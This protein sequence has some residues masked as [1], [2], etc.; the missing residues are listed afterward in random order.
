VLNTARFII[1]KQSF[2]NDRALACVAFFLM[3]P[4]FPIHPSPRFTSVRLLPQAVRPQENLH[5]VLSRAQLTPPLRS[6]SFWLRF[7]PDGRYL[8]AQDFSGVSI[9]SVEPLKFLGYIEVENTYHAFFTPDSKAIRIVSSDLRVAT[10]KVENTDQLD[11][12]TLLKG[13]SCLSVS[14]SNS[15][16]RF[17]C[18]QHDFTLKVFDLET[19]EETYSETFSDN[20]AVALQLETDGLH[21]GQIAYIP[22]NPWAPLAHNFVEAIPIFFSPDGQ[23]LIIAAPRGGASRIDLR[24]KRKL[25]V[26]GS[27]KGHLHSTFVWLEGDRVLAFEH[28]A[29]D[30]S[31]IFSLEAG[32]V[33]SAVPFTTD[34][35]QAASNA[36]YLL[37][38]QAGTPGARVFDLIENRLLDVPDN[39]GLD[40]FGPVL[41][42]L[43][44]N[45]DLF[46]YHIGDKLPYRVTQVPLGSLTQIRTAELDSSLKFIG[47]SVDGQGALFSVSD[48]RRIR[49][50]SRFLAAHFVEDN[51]AFL[52]FPATQHAQAKILKLDISS[53][54]SSAL[55]S[56]G[57]EFLCSGGPVLFN[58]LSEQAGRELMADQSAGG[59]DARSGELGW[60]RLIGQGPQL[61]DQL[62]AI[63]PRSGE[64]L[65]K[66]VFYEE[67]PIVF[68]DP[69]GKR[70]LLGWMAKSDRARAA[71]SHFPVAHQILK[72][73][74]IGEYDTFF[75]VL[76]ARTGKA[77][78]AV[79]VQ[80]GSF[81]WSFDEAFSVGDTL[82]LMKDGMRVF[83]FSLTDGTLKAKLFGN[84]PA[85][86]AASDLLV[87][88]EG[89]GKLT[90]Y[91]TNTGAKLDQLFFPD[92]IAYSHFSDDGKRLFVLTWHQVAFVLDVSAVRQAA[93]SRL[94]PD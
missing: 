49:N 93:S 66:R 41:A 6:G 46:L 88:N 85:A 24:T 58:Y 42:L 38:H 79:L 71:A 25:N 4:A 10:R 1:M 36:R 57:W 83:V 89:D 40:I 74:K 37:L 15:G 30:T 47:L 33:Q 50:F 94:S 5:G 59:S 31:T 39:I 20:P 61:S 44:E 27:L 70:L 69:Q 54:T 73:A 86:S 43:A 72:K 18:L 60:Q 2:L 29:S 7:S 55:A 22:T 23:Q 62:Q 35:S 52:A 68:P 34:S 77:V 26:P 90:L 13:G 9:F 45:G 19:S 28:G 81:A 17:A 91:D 84:E 32:A 3:A 51:A 92:R 16:Q 76:D 48:G 12:K 53:G 14:I 65:W 80:I 56:L 67:N 82:F 78:G 11:Q 21:A 87:L 64:V 63:D 75:E 8:L